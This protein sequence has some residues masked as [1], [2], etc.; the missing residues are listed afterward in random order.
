MSSNVNKGFNGENRP[1]ILLCLKNFR[2]WKFVDLQKPRRS[3]EIVHEKIRTRPFVILCLILIR[4]LIPTW[5]L[6]KLCVW[7]IRS[8]QAIRFLAEGDEKKKKKTRKETVLTSRQ[9]SKKNLVSP[10][11]TSQTEPHNPTHYG[12]DGDG[13]EP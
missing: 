3:C 13:P 7:E 9:V 6:L 8:C 2:V 10:C 1:F 11:P 5:V 4:T 12:G